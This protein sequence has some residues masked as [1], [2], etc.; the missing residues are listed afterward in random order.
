MS[1]GV[2]A[3]WGFPK[4]F[5][6]PSLMDILPAAMATMGS[7]SGPACQMGTVM[8]RLVAMEEGMALETMVGHLGAT[9][10]LLG[11]MVGLL[12]VMEED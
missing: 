1:T 11:A 10:A 12:E 3:S 2:C 4:A 9:E 5:L 7:S 6:I 8:E